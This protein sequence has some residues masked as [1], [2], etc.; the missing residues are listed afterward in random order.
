MALSA[1]AAYRLYKIHH[2]TRTGK[3]LWVLIL[4]R[5]TV[6]FLLLFILLKPHIYY[7]REVNRYPHLAVFYDYSA[8][9]RTVNSEENRLDS[10]KTA[11]AIAGHYTFPHRVFDFSGQV[12]EWRGPEV[13]DSLEPHGNHRIVSARA[14]TEADPFSGR[15]K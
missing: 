12:S 14:G 13:P 5:S 10:L 11:Q 1:W 7:S 3:R 4:L 9:M 15:S 2:S 6:L 8:S